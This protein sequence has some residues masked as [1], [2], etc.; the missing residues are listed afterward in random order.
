MKTIGLIGGMS[1]ESTR[2]Y[3]ELLNRGVQKSLGGLHSAQILLSSLDM[4]RV[5]GMQNEGRWQEAGE[6]L[7]VEAVRLERAGADVIALAANTMHKCAPRIQAAVAVPFLHIVD[8]LL[9][10]LRA[11]RRRR[12]LLLATR[13]TMEERFFLE[14]LEANQMIPMVPALA[15][16]IVLH[17]II[18]QELCKGI[19]ST[20][21]VAV[22]QRLTIDAGQQG[23]DSVILGCTELGTLAAAGPL[24]LPAYDTAVIHAGALVEFA[25]TDTGAWGA[26]KK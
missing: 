15:D 17:D 11:D 20:A 4:A 19:V 10:Q 13:F 23:A 5:A 25:L 24:V 7:A 2:I 1:W 6:W 9:A 26:P 22:L 12:P 21:A 14:R 3:Y 18:Y 16:R 8:P